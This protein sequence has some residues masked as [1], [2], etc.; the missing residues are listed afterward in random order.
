MIIQEKMFYDKMVKK[1]KEANSIF[2]EIEQIHR[3]RNLNLQTIYAD[4]PE[5]KSFENIDTCENELI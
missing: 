2:Q 3:K 5:I 1:L 4:I